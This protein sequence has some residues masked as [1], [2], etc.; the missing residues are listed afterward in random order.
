MTRESDLFANFERM[1]R[2]ID[3]LFGDIWE[4]AGYVPQGRPSFSPKID[5]YQCGEP[6]IV[7]VKA[8]LAGVEVGELNLEVQGRELAISGVRE[9]RE[10]KS[11]AYQQI[12]IESGYFERRVDLGADVEAEQAKATYE[13]GVLKVELPLALPSSKAAR[14]P[15]REQEGPSG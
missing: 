8:D 10:S 9:T 12:E 15:I 1:R 6:R 7:V 4:R 11:R 14:V 3:E 5:V 13:D 2:Q